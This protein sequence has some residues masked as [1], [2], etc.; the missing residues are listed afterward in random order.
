[1]KTIRGGRVLACNTKFVSKS[2]HDV[3]NVSEK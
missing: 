1:M 2:F 3:V